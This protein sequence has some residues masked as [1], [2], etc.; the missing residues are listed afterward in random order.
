M[1]RAVAVLARR[2]RA[3]EEADADGLVVGPRYGEGIARQAAEKS[4]L[5][6]R[7]II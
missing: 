1:G 3:C 7:A 5:R 6:A 4:H 2:A